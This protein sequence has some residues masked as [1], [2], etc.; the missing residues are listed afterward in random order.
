MVKVERTILSSPKKWDTALAVDRSPQEE[1]CLA[2]SAAS[3]PLFH[4]QPQG[5]V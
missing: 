1:S 5:D 4:P 2:C 3:S